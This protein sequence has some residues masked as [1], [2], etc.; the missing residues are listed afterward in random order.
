MAARDRVGVGA[1]AETT[2]V[3]AGMPVSDANLALQPTALHGYLECAVGAA[4][5]ERG[6]RREIHERPSCPRPVSGSDRAVARRACQRADQ[7]GPGLPGADLDL[8][9]PSER[10]SNLP[11]GI[12][13]HVRAE[14]P[15][16]CRL[17]RPRVRARL[18]YAVPHGVRLLAGPHLRRRALRGGCGIALLL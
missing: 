6:R 2:I 15:D 8:R 12:P 11:D 18:E 13:V 5:L 4:P 9:E 1:G 16:L 7:G 17:R 10:R 14:L 3:P